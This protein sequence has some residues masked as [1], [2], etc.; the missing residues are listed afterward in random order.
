M[1]FYVSNSA[2]DIP[3]HSQIYK[4]LSLLNLGGEPME[5]TPMEE[6]IV[7]DFRIEED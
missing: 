3:P 4:L 6:L 7:V 2:C 5:G 1:N